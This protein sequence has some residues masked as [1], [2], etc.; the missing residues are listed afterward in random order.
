MEL[1]LTAT[2]F[3]NTTR[4]YI[5]DHLPVSYTIKHTN[6]ST[7]TASSVNLTCVFENLIVPDSEITAN[8]VLKVNDTMVEVHASSLPTTIALGTTF[9]VDFVII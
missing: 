4:L 9:A 1:E 5:G 6:T 3:T 8:K 2:N 7:A